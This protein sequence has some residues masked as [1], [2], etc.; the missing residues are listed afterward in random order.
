MEEKIIHIQR[1]I[2]IELAVPKTATNGEIAEMMRRSF[3]PDGMITDYDGTYRIYD[4]K[5]VNNDDDDQDAFVVV[6]WPESQELCEYE[7]YTE[8]CTFISGEELP[9]CSYL[10]NKEW[11]S[12][13]RNGE[14]RRIEDLI[15]C[16]ELQ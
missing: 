12:R 15:P 1:T 7:D 16:E 14:L 8:Y 11:Y 6:S 13:L 9:C 3:K 10:V 4:V 2:D 5:V